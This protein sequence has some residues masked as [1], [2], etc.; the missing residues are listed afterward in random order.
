M[1]VFCQTCSKKKG[2]NVICDLRQIDS[3]RRRDPKRVVKIS[4]ENVQKAD[5]YIPS[6]I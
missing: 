6:T 2:L 4:E 1:G 5:F 3:T